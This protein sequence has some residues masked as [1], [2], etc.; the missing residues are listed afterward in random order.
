[1][2]MDASEHGSDVDD[3]ISIMENAE[4]GA[5]GI[6]MNWALLRCSFFYYNVVDL[7]N[8]PSASVVDE[9]NLSA[10]VP[11]RPEQ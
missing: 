5:A 4:S 9:Q 2:H 8:T 1:M 10:L 7:F 11:K 3:N 6:W